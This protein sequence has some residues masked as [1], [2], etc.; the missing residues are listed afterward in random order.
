MPSAQMRSLPSGLTASVALGRR[1]IGAGAD[2]LAFE[3]VSGADFGFLA[4]GDDALPP[5]A[6]SC[7][8]CQPLHVDR[9]GHILPRSAESCRNLAGPSC[10][11]RVANCRPLPDQSASGPEICCLSLQG[12]ARQCAALPPGLAGAI[13]QGRLTLRGLSPVL[14]HVQHALLQLVHGSH[15]E[16]SVQRAGR[17]CRRPRLP[18]GLMAIR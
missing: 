12:P 2:L 17:L 14:F 10:Q 3:G 6:V 5:A 15:R 11:F 1:R 4:L 13:R 7:T 8:P 9:G 16:F 18:S